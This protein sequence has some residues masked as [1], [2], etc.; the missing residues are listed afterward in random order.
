M[1]VC[2]CVCVCACTLSRVQLFA[3]R[4]TVTRQASL[5]MGFSRQE[6]H[7]GC[8]P[9]GD[10]S[11]PE[12]KPVFLKSPAFAGVFFTTSATWEALLKPHFP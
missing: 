12:I 4:G 6:Y 3:T 9:P 11:D 10:L 8:P 1:C 7:N 2:V 5:S